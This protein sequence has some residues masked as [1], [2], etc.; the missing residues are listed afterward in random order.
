[1]ISEPAFGFIWRISLIL[2]GIWNGLSNTWFN[3]Y[4]RLLASSV[5]TK[6]KLSLRVSRFLDDTAQY[7]L[8]I[9]THLH[10][11]V[12]LT[13]SRTYFPTLDSSYVS[14]AHINTLQILTFLLGGISHVTILDFCRFRQHISLSIGTIITAFRYIY[15]WGAPANTLRYLKSLRVLEKLEKSIKIEICFH[16]VQV[17]P[18]VQ[19]SEAARQVPIRY[20]NHAFSSHNSF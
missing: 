5:Y 19:T 15:F 6:A 7:T 4:N 16:G 2:K 8:H 3:T 12:S 17:Y 11:L 14:S 10:I 13:H 9:N 20:E 1:M 18:V